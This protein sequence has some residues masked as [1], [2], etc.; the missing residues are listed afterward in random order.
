MRGWMGAAIACIAIFA[1][2]A[3]AQI[4]SPISECLLYAKSQEAVLAACTRGIGSPGTSKSDL[5]AAYRKRGTTYSR[6]KDYDRA[7]ADLTEVVR[8]KPGDSDAYYERGITHRLRASYDLAIADLTRALRL[9]P[10]EAD[11][12][13][14]R[15]QSHH[16]KKDYD[17]A[18]ADYTVAIQLSPNSEPL[19]QL[20]SA[21]H[22]LKADF[23][24]AI[25]DY[26]ELIRLQP[27]NVAL[28]VARGSSQ[29]EI[30]RY[31][32][33]L[34]DLTEA[35]RID[36]D[37]SSALRWRALA[38][39]RTGDTSL[40][41]KDYEAILRLRDEQSTGV[42]S[43]ETARLALAALRLAPA[44]P[45]A[46]PA[47]ATGPTVPA[48]PLG[49]RVALVVANSNYRDIVKLAN[50]AND[51]RAVAA[52]FKRLGF[53]EVMERHDLGL[54]EMVAALKEFGD[55]TTDADWAV[56]YFAGHGIEMNGVPYLVPVDA[57][58]QRDTHVPD[59]T[60]PLERVL[61]K[62]QSARKLRL[63][64]LDACRN[65][66]FVARMIRTAGITRSIGRGLAAIEPGSGV[67]VAYS[68]KHGTTAQ[69][70]TGALSPFAEA[71]VENIERPGLEINFLFRKVRDGVLIRTAN[72]QEPFFYGSLS[73]EYLYFK[74]PL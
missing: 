32:G 57:K 43:H 10:D 38:H 74:P 39:A 51:V 55:Q 61:D 52:A 20:R 59:E 8:Q 30:K 35:I 5:V 15:A 47:V 66:P 37:N 72:A 31:K 69:D 27:K 28:Y 71:L 4:Y 70:G 41:R 24:N 67:L 54:S 48:A 53:A 49:R 9:K 58:L 17:R 36:P 34:A 62:V 22:V 56:V 42:S 63:V 73:S 3:A 25:A 33:A 18:I 2:P 19:L 64:F 14:E 11:Y 16:A 6:L 40:A 23:R 65:N 7:I 68:A 13:S 21:V 1:E 45:A 46:A 12:Y 60:V 26:T 29:I 44:T 50:P